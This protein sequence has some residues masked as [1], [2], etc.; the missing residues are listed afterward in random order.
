LEE[1][2]ILKLEYTSNLKANI[3][4]KLEQE[5]KAEKEKY[6]RQYLNDNYKQKVIEN[7]R[8]KIESRESLK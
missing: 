7:K 8:K 1:K 5:V 3:D 6:F 2:E 4:E